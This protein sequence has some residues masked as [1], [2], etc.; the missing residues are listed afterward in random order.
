MEDYVNILFVRSTMREDLRVIRSQ[1]CEIAE[2]E[3]TKLYRLAWRMQQHGCKAENVETC[4]NEAR[5]LHMTGYPERL[6]RSDI[7]WKYA[8]KY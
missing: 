1:L 2:K 7:V 8:F 5:T 6:L 3:A 4:R